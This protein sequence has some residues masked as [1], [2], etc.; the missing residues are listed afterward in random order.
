MSNVEVLYKC[1]N[2]LGEGIT[3]SSKNNTLYCA[4]D[5]IS[6]CLESL[7]NKDSNKNSRFFAFK[8][9]SLSSS[10]LREVLNNPNNVAARDSISKASTHA[11]IA[12]SSTRTAVAHSISYPL[13]SIYGVPHGL[14]CSFTLKYLL[15]INLETLGKNE[16][17]LMVLSDILELL[18]EIDFKGHLEKY[19]SVAELLSLSKDMSHPDRIKNYSGKKFQSIEDVL[20]SSL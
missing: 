14:A 13:T 16:V 19:L 10:N 6:H 7:W 1:N 20:I 2:T 4:L 15:K 3:Y 8:S 9:L 11:G 17:E 18:D 5:S 12:I